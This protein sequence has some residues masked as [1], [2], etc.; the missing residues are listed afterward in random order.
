MKNI[1]QKQIKEFYKEYHSNIQ[2]KSKTSI[3]NIGTKTIW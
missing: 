1:S 3:K 2:Y